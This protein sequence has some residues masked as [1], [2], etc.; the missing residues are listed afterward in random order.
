MSEERVGGPYPSPFSAKVKLKNLLNL[1]IRI[2]KLLLKRQ[3]KKLSVGPRSWENGENFW[4][5]VCMVI[6]WCHAGELSY[7]GLQFHFV[8]SNMQ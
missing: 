2:V 4:I 3:T 6:I 1:I 8:L 5:R 7:L